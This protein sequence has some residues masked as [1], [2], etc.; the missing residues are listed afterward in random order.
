MNSFIKTIAIIDNNGINLRYP[1]DSQGNLTLDKAMFI[2][3]EELVFHLE[4]FI[5]QLNLISIELFDK[6]DGIA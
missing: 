4:K 6:G 3:V 2:N 5:E 1:H